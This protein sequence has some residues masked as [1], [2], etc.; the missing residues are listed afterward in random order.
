MVVADQAHPTLRIEQL[1]ETYDPLRSHGVHQD[2]GLHGGEIDVPGPYLGQEIRMGLQVSLD[3]RRLRPREGRH[4]PR[5]EH[6][7]RKD[8]GSRVEVRTLVRGNQDHAASLLRASRP[9]QGV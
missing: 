9:R 8:P 2:E 4:G 5:V 1:P 6:Q 3:R 7:R